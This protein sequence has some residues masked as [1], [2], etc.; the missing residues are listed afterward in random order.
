LPS[1]HRGSDFVLTA[2]YR[3]ETDKKKSTDRADYQDTPRPLA[4]MAKD[5]TDGFRIEPHCHP[6]AQ[7]TWAASGVMTVTAA[8]G[9]WVVPPNRALWIPAQI[10]HEIRMSGAVAM[11]AIYID[12]AVAGTVAEDCKVILV[13]PLLRALMLELVA[14]PLDYDETG[15][16]GHVAALFLDEI[17]VLDAQPLHVP[18][19][20][21]KR[22]R[23]LC[24]ALLRNP[25]RRE[26][27]QEWSTLCGASSRTL[28]RLFERE[29]GMRFVDWRHLVR[30]TEALVR[31]AQGHDVG[32]VARAVGYESVSAF[33]AMFRQILGKT[34]RNYF[35]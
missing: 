27:L 3:R 14:A 32:V 12:P 11:R 6:R 15:R 34:P 20:N 1:I 17:R 18:M 23:R 30:L 4:G 35:D 16:F 31:L 19:P 8:R 22:L 5:F 28:A 25:G 10:E 13:S 33:S 2:N 7:L 21:D 24:E 9:N 29:T 26:T